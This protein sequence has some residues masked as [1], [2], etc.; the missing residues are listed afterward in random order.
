MSEPNAPSEPQETTPDA[1]A[2]ADREP[3]HFAGSGGG[4]S[5]PPLASTY[6]DNDD[7]QGPPVFG[8]PETEHAVAA[9]WGH[10]AL[11]GEQYGGT[12]V[13][14]HDQAVGSE[15]GQHPV[16]P[17]V[18]GGRSGANKRTGPKPI[19]GPRFSGSP[20]IA[21]LGILSLLIVIAIMAFLAVKVLGGVEEG[22]RRAGGGNAVVTPGGVVVGSDDLTGSAGAGATGGG[23]TDGAKAA[24]CAA[25]KAT[26]ATA[27]Q[28]YEATNGGPP[29][30]L[31][32][33]VQAGFLK[34][35]PG[36]F[37]I[38]SGAAGTDIVGVGVCEG[39]N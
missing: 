35:D 18:A 17:P 19:R 36:S 34:E 30:S 39:T 27:V 9:G 24:T 10:D 21:G 8:R 29:D 20:M 3:R 12:W 25:N 7:A 11:E 33:L 4:S 38:H 31:A 13:K 16:V 1:A 37:E 14:P 32:T 28:A 23:I 2:H 5:L 15:T 6:H 22:T 26:I